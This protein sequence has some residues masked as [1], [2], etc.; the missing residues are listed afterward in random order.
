MHISPIVS[1]QAQDNCGWDYRT[2]YHD[3]LPLSARGRR[4]L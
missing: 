2:L 4:G 1:F 3:Y